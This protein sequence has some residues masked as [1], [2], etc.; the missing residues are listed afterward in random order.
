MTETWYA[1]NSVSG[2]ESDIIHRRKPSYSPQSVRLNLPMTE[3]V[4]SYLLRNG[5]YSID[6]GDSMRESLCVLES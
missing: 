2:P 5:L 6:G 4:G 3:T 1:Q